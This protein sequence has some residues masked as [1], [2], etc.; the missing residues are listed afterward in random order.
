[1]AALGPLVGE[2]VG[3]ERA[4]I[5]ISDDGLRHSVRIGDAVDIEVEEVV[6]L[7]SE[8]GAPV[9]LVG[10]F[11]PAGPEL[12]VSRATR[13]KVDAFGISFDGNSAFSRSEF[14]WAA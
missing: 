8:S 11:H 2:T 6:P 13:A 7:G 4:A 5:E 12:T 3:V 10:V 9:K 14:S 1:M